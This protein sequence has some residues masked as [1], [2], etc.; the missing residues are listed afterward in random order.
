MVAALTEEDLTL[1]VGGYRLSAAVYAMADLGVPDALAIAPRTAQ[2]LAELLSVDA[3]LLNRL[4]R[5]LTS[6]GALICDDDG[7]FENTG[8][9]AALVSGGT[10]DM[11]LGWAALPGLFP[12]WSHLAT[13][14]RGGRPPFEAAHGVDLHGFFAA[15]PDQHAAYLAANGSTLESFEEAAATLD[16]A[17]ATTVVSVGGGHGF[18]LVPLLRTWPRLRAVLTDLPDAL[19]GA[20]EKLEAFGVADRVEVIPGDARVSVPAGDR[21]VLSTVLRCLS[22]ADVVAV[23]TSCRVAASPGTAMHVIE[24]PVPDGPPVHPSATADLTAWV[25][26]G[27]ADRTVEQWTELHAQAG[28]ALTTVTPIDAPFA[29]LTSACN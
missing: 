24:M 17:T 6:R 11:I 19:V 23:L 14:V 3:S 15:H 25:A 29:V 5:M 13:S 18:E 9:S 28:W 26:Y 10:R 16:F 20:A 22:D 8:L 7:R 27:G 21:Y 12:A 4:L 1:V 2:E